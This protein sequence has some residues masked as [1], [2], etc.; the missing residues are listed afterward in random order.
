MD[1]RVLAVVGAKGGVGKTTTSLNLAAALAEDGR[2]VAVVEAD[3][4]MANAVDFLDVDVESG[5]TFHDVL[6]G[7]AGVDE[8]TYPAA[9]GFDVVPS[10]TELDGFVS[11]DLDRFPGALD[12][13][14]AR[15]DAVVVDTGAGV[16]RETVVPTKLADAS[17]LVSTPRVASVRDADKTMTV[18]ERAGAPVG[19]VV[20]TKSGTGRSPPARRIARFLDTDLLGHVPHDEAIPESQDAGQPAVAYAPD[21]DAAMAYRGVADA[22]RRRPDM[23]GMTVGGGSSGFRFGSGASADGGTAGDVFR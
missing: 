4:A 12:A 6:A 8:A 22:L 3:L 14:K 19:G 1:G 20:L 16:S 10:G 13:L 7:G 5:R 17:V 18:A 2:A 11:A 21:S 9:G 23:L 15:Y